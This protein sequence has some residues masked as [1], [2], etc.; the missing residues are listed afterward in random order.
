M[1]HGSGSVRPTANSGRTSGITSAAN[2]AGISSIS[3]TATDSSGNSDAS[4]YQI[5]AGAPAAI[6]NQEWFDSPFATGDAASDAAPDHDG[7]NN[8]LEFA[9]GQ[10]PKVGTRAPI[11]LVP[12]PDAMLDFGYLRSKA[13]IAEG[14][15]YSVEWSENLTT[16]SWTNAGVIQDAASLD[17]GDTIRITARIPGGGSNARFVRLRI[18]KP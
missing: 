15:T 2:T 16:G 14:I 12:A 11:T 6:W 3:V 1:R 13:A 5:T 8:L 18:H 4:L 10:S 17:K 9:T 7:E